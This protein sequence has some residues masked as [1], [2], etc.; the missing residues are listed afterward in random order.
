[1]KKATAISQG[2]RRLLVSVRRDSGDDGG[3]LAT[4]PAVALGGLGS[5]EAVGV[6]LRDPTR[7]FAELF[8]L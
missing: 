2:S 1:M 8:D 4:P 5:F 6:F 3:R 7:R